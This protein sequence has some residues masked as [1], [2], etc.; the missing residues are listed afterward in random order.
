MPNMKST[1]SIFLSI[2]IP[3]YNVA[4]Y[5]PD[6]LH[7]LCQLSDAADCEFIFVDD[8]STDGTTSILQY[9][10][11]TDR[12]AVF[13]RQPNAGVSA[14]RNAALQ[15]AKG[16]YILPVDGDDRLL[17]DAISTIRQ[18]I[19]EADLLIAPVQILEHGRCIQDSIPFPEGTY[20]PYTLFRNCKVFPTGPKLV[21]KADI[22]RTHSLRF[23]EATHCG[24]VFAFTCA[25]L[26]H[27]Q[28]I[29]VSHHCFYQYVMRK[30]SAIHA[31][32][33]QKDVTVLHIVDDVTKVTDASIRALPSYNATLFRMCTTFTYNKYAKEGLL[34]NPALTV[35][36]QV[37]QHKGLRHCSMR[38][39]RSIGYYGKDRF[40][41]LYIMLTG[42]WG[43][44]L[45]GRVFRFRK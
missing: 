25:F 33:F 37:V 34:D 3:C 28:T 5:L 20:T 12:R 2:V 11:Q 30:T 19:Q 38:L 35:I 16:Q 7:S 41:A 39:V 1:N 36:K 13:I 9:F 23:N 6:T 44:R 27:C 14:A 21:Y 8:G 22:I 17:P 31:P 10:A 32:N 24:E 40:M 15:E 45:L 29:K 26:S 18:A 43:Y 42:L 4:E